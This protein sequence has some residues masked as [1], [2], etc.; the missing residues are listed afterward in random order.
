MTIKYIKFSILTNRKFRRH[1]IFRRNNECPPPSP[2]SFKRQNVSH[3][4][5]ENFLDTR[6]NVKGRKETIKKKVWRIREKT[7]RNY[8]FFLNSIYLKNFHERRLY[9]RKVNHINWEFF[10]S[11]CNTN[12][13][14]SNMQIKWKLNKSSLGK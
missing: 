11:M 2:T 14:F 5:S 13:D 1:Y 3:Y 12:G 10:F 4:P 7:S 9:K 6:S 8:Y